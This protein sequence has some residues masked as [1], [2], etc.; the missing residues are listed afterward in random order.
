MRVASGEADGEFGEPV[1][2]IGGADF[3][4]YMAQ[5]DLTEKAPTRNSSTKAAPTP[6]STPANSLDSLSL[7]PNRRGTHFKRTSETQ[8]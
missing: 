6:P 3:I 1:L 8:G 5:G 7:F 4:L 2:R